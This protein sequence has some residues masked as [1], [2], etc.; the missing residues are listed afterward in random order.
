M[1]LAFFDV[2]QRHRKY[3]SW[4]ALNFI[5]HKLTPMLDARYSMNFNQ[6]HYPESSIE[7]PDVGWALP[8]VYN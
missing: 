4:V 3:L 2:K 7:I 6:R 8:T 5:N 1:R